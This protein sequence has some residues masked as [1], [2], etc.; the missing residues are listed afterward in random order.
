M[1]IYTPN[2]TP[3]QIDYIRAN[4]FQNQKQ[5]AEHLGVHIW[6]VHRFMSANRIDSTCRK[7]KSDVFEMAGEGFFNVDMY[8]KNNATL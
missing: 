4:K 6:R 8:A 2:L 1:R 3:E 7:W 5:I